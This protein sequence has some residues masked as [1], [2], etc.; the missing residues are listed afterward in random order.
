MKRFLSLSLEPVTS[1]QLQNVTTAGLEEGPSQYRFCGFIQ[2]NRNRFDNLSYKT[3][4]LKMQQV[5]Y[6][7]EID[8]YEYND[9]VCQK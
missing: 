4:F 5:E 7:V 9:H 2:S 1:A 6:T 3:Q 8:S